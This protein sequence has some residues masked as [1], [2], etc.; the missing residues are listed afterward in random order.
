MRS[1]VIT[2]DWTARVAH[3]LSVLYPYYDLDIDR[4]RIVG[5]AEAHREIFTSSDRNQESI[6]QLKAGIAE[7]ARYT[8]VRLPQ[9]A[10]REAL[11]ATEIARMKLQSNRERERSKKQRWA[12]LGWTV[13]RTNLW[14]DDF[15][16]LHYEHGRLQCEP[17][18][19]KWE[20]KSLRGK[21][22]EER[23]IES[24][25]EER[26]RKLVKDISKVR[27][28]IELDFLERGD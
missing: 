22:E 17:V 9:V 23:K 5:L 21:L 18:N 12:R 4:Q 14:S 3:C 24:E 16:R 10:A 2:Q 11:L 27:V 7:V 19:L 28:P 15:E 1:G 26:M 13:Q 8:G 25:L 6:K 20:R